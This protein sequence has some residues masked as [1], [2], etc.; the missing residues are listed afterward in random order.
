MENK[1]LDLIKKD[2]EKG[3][4]VLIEE[5]AGLVYTIVKNKLVAY[6]S[7]EDIEETVSDVFVAFYNNINSF[8]ITRGTISAYISTIAR[9][10][11][12]D[13]LRTLNTHF[14]VSVDENDFI[15]IPD[16]INLENEFEKKLLSHN[17]AEV[18][19]SLGEPDS[20]IVFRKYFLGEGSKEIAHFTG[21]TDD[22]VRKR[23]SRALCKIKEAMEGDYYEN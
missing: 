12:T 2:A 10:K 3:M 17:L 1:L 6:C 20:T 7:K 23:L 19:K 14:E 5:Y 13:R 15:E 21:L 9:R 8:D 22:N 11:A 16:S 4:S 18:I